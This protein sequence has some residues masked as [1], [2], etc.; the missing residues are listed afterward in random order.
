[1]DEVS[2]RSLRKLCESKEFLLCI[3]L[4]NE[5]SPVCGS[6]QR[7]WAPIIASSK[8]LV[9]VFSAFCGSGTVK[10]AWCTDWHV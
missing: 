7:L 4:P 2:E 5:I 8:P 6:H 10:S 1:M 3:R 9:C